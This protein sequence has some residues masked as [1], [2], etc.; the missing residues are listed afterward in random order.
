MKAALALDMCHIT[1]SDW[2]EPLLSVKK[3]CTDSLTE[4]VMHKDIM[5]ACLYQWK[6]ALSLD[7]CYV[8]IDVYATMD[9]HLLQHGVT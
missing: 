8:T 1:I 7:M 2:K 6:A 3:P 9:L 5:V 4:K